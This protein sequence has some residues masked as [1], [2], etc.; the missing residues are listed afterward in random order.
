MMLTWEDKEIEKETPVFQT[1]FHELQTKD[2]L[3]KISILKSDSAMDDPDTFRNNKGELSNTYRRKAAEA[4]SSRQ[5]LRAILKNGEC[6]IFPSQVPKGKFIRDIYTTLVDSRWRWTFAM[7]S[8]GFFGSW[9]IFAVAWWLIAFLHGDLEPNHL[10]MNQLAS[11]WTPCVLEV[12]GFSSCFLFSVETQHTTGYG[13]RTPT[14][15]CSE[16]IFLMCIQNVAGSIIETFL[17]GIVFAKLIRPK[18]RTHTLKFSKYA[19]INKRDDT[20]CLMFRVGDMRQKSRII[21]AKIKAQLIRRKQTKEGENLTNFQ[22]KLCISADEC[23]GDLFFIWPMIIVHKIDS[24][25]PF[26]YMSAQDLSRECFEIIV[27]LEG[28]IESTDQKTQ[29]RSSYLPD[30]VLWGHRFEPMHSLDV[31][32]QGYRINYDMFDKTVTVETPLCSAAQLVELRGAQKTS[33]VP[34][35]TVRTEIRVPY[36]APSKK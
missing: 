1:Q 15:E 28:T 16:A 29:A 12:Y 2:E 5:N 24:R 26:Y 19:V 20:L 18:R 13:Q 30:E 35:I 34:K 7:L 17:I 23:E 27:T 3:R 11:N 14:E 32:K 22:S 36:V 10:P 21:E 25:S 6:N 33:N 8:M 9:F 4:L 31:D